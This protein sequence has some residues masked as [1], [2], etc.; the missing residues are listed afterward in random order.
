MGFGCTRASSFEKSNQKQLS[1]ILG[2]VSWIRGTCPGRWS[3]GRLWRVSTLQLCIHMLRKHFFLVMWGRQPKAFLI[4]DL[5][6][7]LERG[8]GLP[9]ISHQHKRL[10]SSLPSSLFCE[11]LLLYTSLSEH[12]ERLGFRCCLQPVAIQRGWR[13]Y[14][15]CWQ[16]LF[17]K[18][19]KPPLPKSLWLGRPAL[20]VGFQMH[21]CVSFVLS[22]PEETMRSLQSWLFGKLMIGQHPVLPKFHPGCIH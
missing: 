21:R 9:R 7:L 6:L 14:V 16:D 8:G 1:R 10:K 4:C 13:H 2:T 3:F 17:N 20:G 22:F 5:L 12:P 19:S 11:L 18:G 15:R